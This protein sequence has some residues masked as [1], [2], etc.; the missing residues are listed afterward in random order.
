MLCSPGLDLTDAK[1]FCA[2]SFFL[3]TTCRLSS[4]LLQARGMRTGVS[5]CTDDAYYLKIEQNIYTRRTY[6]SF[7]CA[8]VAPCRSADA[9]MTANRTGAMFCRA[10][11]QL[12]RQRHNNTRSRT[13]WR[14]GDRAGHQVPWLEEAAERCFF[15]Y[16]PTPPPPPLTWFPPPFKF[17]ETPAVSSLYPM[18]FHFQKVVWH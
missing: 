3:V 16:S 5:F 10:E 18:E 7:R 2:T 14:T 12:C 6:V 13:R 1:L 17:V 9:T 11:W 8:D 15:F 4:L